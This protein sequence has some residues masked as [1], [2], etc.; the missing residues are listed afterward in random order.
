[1]SLNLK[2]KAF[3]GELEKALYFILLLGVKKCTLFC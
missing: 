2:N 1:M 3:K